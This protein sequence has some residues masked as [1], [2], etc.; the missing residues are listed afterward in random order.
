[1]TAILASCLEAALRLLGHPGW[2]GSVASL[3]AQTS[4][5]GLGAAYICIGLPGMF[6]SSADRHD[7]LRYHVSCLDGMQAY[8]LKSN[9]M[10][11]GLLHPSATVMDLNIGAALWMAA[12]AEGKVTVAHGASPSPSNSPSQSTHNQQPN[13]HDS[14]STST[15]PLVHV[16]E[17]SGPGTGLLS[18]DCRIESDKLQTCDTGTTELCAPQWQLQHHLQ[19]SGPD[20]ECCRSASLQQ[21]APAM[22]GSPAM[23]HKQAARDDAPSSAT[24]HQAES[25]ADP[26]NLA[27]SERGPQYPAESETGPQNL[28]ESEAG[29]QSLAEYEARPQNL[30]E[31]VAEPQHQ[32]CSAAPASPPD[33]HGVH[34]KAGTTSYEW[35]RSAARVVLLGHG[36]DE[37]HAGY[38]R[39]RT[40]FRKHVS[41]YCLHVH[42]V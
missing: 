33:T 26:Q 15:H 13:T 19:L 30:A 28:A 18:A 8:L 14:Q 5:L 21:A 12:R 22:D 37:Q 10:L 1:M 9:G 36:A 31:S 7:I 3:A 27:E 23:R 24:C 40:S 25:E 29:P 35:Y 34:G 6:T 20:A 11:A 16:T 17:T 41:P 2:C 4:C 42:A 38:G 39:H 32:Q